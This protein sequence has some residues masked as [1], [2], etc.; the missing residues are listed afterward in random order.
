[1]APGAR[2]VDRVASSFGTET[3]H[4]REAL[5]GPT[6][7]T[8]PRE[9]RALPSAHVTVGEHGGILF[10]ACGA[11]SAA[12][13]LLDCARHPWVGHVPCDIVPGRCV[14]H[15]SRGEQAVVAPSRAT[16]EDGAPPRQIDKFECVGRPSSAAERGLPWPAEE[17][18]EGGEGMKVVSWDTRTA[19]YDCGCTAEVDGVNPPAII[20]C[21]THFEAIAAARLVAEMATLIREVLDGEP[22]GWATRARRALHARRDLVAGRDAVA[23][24]QRA[25]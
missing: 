21:S 17:E 10:G 15:R 19:T 23:G 12:V 2:R 14:I 11:R 18:R 20:Q 4:E 7:D 9:D 8:G 6:M 24:A 16:F 22:P 25:S 3:G 13:G 5:H 1:V